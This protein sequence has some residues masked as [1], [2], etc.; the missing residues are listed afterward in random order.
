MLI[1]WSFKLSVL[2]QGTR[3]EVESTHVYPWVTHLTF[4]TF[5]NFYT[6]HLTSR[7]FWID[8]ICTRIAWAVSLMHYQVTGKNC[9]VSYGFHILF[10]RLLHSQK[11]E[12]HIIGFGKTVNI[13]IHILCG[14][15]FTFLNFTLSNSF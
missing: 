7:N 3:P 9:F 5:P 10:C 2:N 4:L 11:S 13:H 15:Q 6:I 12:F 1:G 14:C 8:E